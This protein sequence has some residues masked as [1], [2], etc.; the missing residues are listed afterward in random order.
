[1]F[2]LEMMQKPSLASG[3]ETVTCGFL[4]EAQEDDLLRGEEWTAVYP[5]VVFAWLSV[6]EQ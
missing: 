6:S 5:R 1:M 4:V 2:M 3:S